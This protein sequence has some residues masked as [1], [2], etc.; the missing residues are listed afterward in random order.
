MPGGQYQ[1]SSSA[2]CTISSSQGGDGSK[3]TTGFSYDTVTYQFGGQREVSPGWC[4]GGS[5]AYENSQVRATNGN[6]RGDGDSGYIGA[7]HV[8]SHSG[9]LKVMVPF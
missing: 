6:V 5:A 2:T 4:G 1:P 8:R 9:T 3:G 7:E